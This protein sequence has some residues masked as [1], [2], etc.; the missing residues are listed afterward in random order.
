[1]GGRCTSCF[2]EI[3]DDSISAKTS[4]TSDAIGRRRKKID[5]LSKTPNTM[6]TKTKTIVSIRNKL[7]DHRF[8][9][10]AQSNSFE[11]CFENIK[12]NVT[13]RTCLSFWND[14][15]DKQKIDLDSNTIGTMKF[16]E[17]IKQIENKQTEKNLSK[18][19][20]KKASSS[21]RTESFF[22]TS[23][24]ISK[25]KQTRISK[26][27]KESS[28]YKNIEQIPLEIN[29]LS[30]TNPT[31]SKDVKRSESFNSQRFSNS[32]SD[33]ERELEDCSNISFYSS[34]SSPKMKLNGG[35]KSITKKRI[36]NLVTKEFRNQNKKSISKEN[37]NRIRISTKQHQQQCLRNKQ[38]IKQL[39]LSLRKSRA[40]I[41]LRKRSKTRRSKTRY[42]RNRS[43]TRSESIR[44]DSMRKK[45]RND[46]NNSFWNQKIESLRL[47]KTDENDNE[48]NIRE[49]RGVGS[50]AGVDH[51][52]VRTD[53]DRKRSKF[54]EP[55]ES[56]RSILGGKNTTSL[57]G[58]TLSVTFSSSRL[59]HSLKQ[60]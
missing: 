3:N 39:S 25:S 17:Q 13:E 8:D 46:R 16:N 48:N 38:N 53:F 36:K 33:L 30:K 29:D 7:N 42:I 32:S 52:L 60:R 43:K 57:I 23:G 19:D 54:R 51:R 35:T 10:K 50:G 26:S 41:T 11:T 58:P 59:E 14:Q 1:M 18:R 20:L 6:K 15:R 24:S 4:D 21:Q 47:T 28:R 55:I 44:R 45:H 34:L 2:D 12:P 49:D 31:K 27:V 22:S 40:T 9:R 56:K 37:G 5:P